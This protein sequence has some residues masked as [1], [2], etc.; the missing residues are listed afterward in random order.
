VVIAL[1]T[2]VAALMISA[3]R[4][5]RGAVAAWGEPVTVVRVVS[6]LPAGSEVSSGAV[7]LVTAPRALVPEGALSKLDQVGVPT[8]AVAAGSILNRLDVEA[9]SAWP[10]F[11]RAVAVPVPAHHPAP[12]PGARIELVLSTHVDPYEPA[13]TQHQVVPAV[14][15]QG[16]D[17][18]WLV[19]VDEAH[20]VTVA[21]ATIS[22]T[23][24]P[25]LL[26]R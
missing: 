3:E 19:E 21:A 4:R 6:P 5:S 26:P 20:A 13:A 17:N 14:V 12:A 9:H 24:V 16:D 22:G 25:V 10:Q 11:G 2:I 18:S 1:A 8:R 15:L 7:E 23:I